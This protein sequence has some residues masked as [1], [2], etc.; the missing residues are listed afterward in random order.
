MIGWSEASK[1]NAFFFSRREMRYSNSNREG[2]GSHPIPLP[3]IK[4]IYIFSYIPIW[5]TAKVPYVLFGNL[6]STF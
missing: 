4:Y 6:Y 2:V 5:Q 3:P 1:N